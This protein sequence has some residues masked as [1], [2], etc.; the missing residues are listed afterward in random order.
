MAPG[1]YR[2]PDRSGPNEPDF[3][4]S[5]LP[6]QL[7]D[8]DGVWVLL[9]RH[10]VSLGELGF[11]VRAA[12]G[13][14]LGAAVGV[15]AEP[16]LSSLL[17]REPKDSREHAFDKEAVHEVVVDGSDLALLRRLGLHE[18][19]QVQGGHRPLPL[20]AGAGLGL[21]QAGGRERGG[22]DDREPRS[23]HRRLWVACN[24][25]H[26]CVLAHKK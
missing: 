17:P 12:Q 13:D 26:P 1:L 10:G 3:R 25:T 9:T 4:W 19:A 21:G 23:V 24:V 8:A 14:H 22:E 11:G 7:Q 6:D 2:G 5:P 18:L 16:D 15:R 20:Q